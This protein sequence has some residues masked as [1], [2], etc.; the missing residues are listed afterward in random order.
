MDRSSGLRVPEFVEGEAQD[1]GVLAVAEEGAEFGF[2]GRGD[3]KVA[4]TGGHMDG[5]VELD[6][7]AL[8]GRFV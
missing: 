7:T 5:A 6:G 3:D 1:G 8:M 4:Y 2:R